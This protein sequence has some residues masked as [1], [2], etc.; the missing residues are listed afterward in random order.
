MHQTG[1]AVRTVLTQ[2]G[3]PRRFFSSAE[4]TA[5]TVEECLRFDAPLHLFTRYAYEDMEVSP[6]V[7]VKSG[8]QIGLLLG[9]ANRDPKAFAEPGRSVRT[10]RTRRTSPSAPASISASARRWRGSNCRSR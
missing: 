1:N 8:E 4:A 5:A 2:G 7:T 6:G 3:D 10:A 9:M